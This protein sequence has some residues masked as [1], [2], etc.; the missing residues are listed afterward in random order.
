MNLIKKKSSLQPNLF[1]KSS[2]T[3][4]DCSR[5]RNWN[6]KKL[7]LK[8]TT[9]EAISQTKMLQRR[10]KKKIGWRKEKNMLKTSSHLIFNENDSFNTQSHRLW[11]CQQ[12][13]LCYWNTH[14]SFCHCQYKAIYVRNNIKLH[15]MYTT[16]ANSLL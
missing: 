11:L 12:T 10:S 9:G 1:S 5:T 14:I 15:S 6:K 3:E 13:I 7:D 8:M 16:N 2:K 4:F